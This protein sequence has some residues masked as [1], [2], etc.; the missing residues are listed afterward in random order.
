MAYRH[1]CG[2]LYLREIERQQVFYGASFRPGYSDEIRRLVLAKR[3]INVFMNVVKSTYGTGKISIWTRCGHC[4]QRYKIEGLVATIDRELT[5]L[6]VLSQQPKCSCS[7]SLKISHNK[8][9]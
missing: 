3:D 5:S 2:F 7:K 1:F 4:L 8:C 9:N 6:R